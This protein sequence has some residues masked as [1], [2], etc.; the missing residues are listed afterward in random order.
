[1]KLRSLASGSSGNSVLVQ[2]EQTTILIDAGYS[3]KKIDQLLRQAGTSA[4]KVDAI[5]VTHEHSDHTAG[6]GVLTRRF[7]IPIYANENTWLAMEKKVGRHRDRD[8]VVIRNERV[9]EIGDLEILPIPIHHDCADPVGYVIRHGNEKISILTDTGFVDR[10]ILE[11]MRGS[12]LYYWEANYEDLLLQQGPYSP[13]SKKRIASELGH[14]SNR[15]SGEALCE[16]LEGRGEEVLLAH[17]SIN[18]NTALCC[19]NTVSEVLVE[20]G[21]AVGSAVHVAVAPRFE[22]SEELSTERVRERSLVKTSEE[23]T[24]EPLLS[25]ATPEGGRA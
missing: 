3:A 16:V 7:H 8:H 6:L 23:S 2:S 25:L 24:T 12:D 11:A 10:T 9:F 5:L 1:M 22:P 20:N 14:L 21:F 13:W 18:N 4:K 19:L 17:M 15:Q